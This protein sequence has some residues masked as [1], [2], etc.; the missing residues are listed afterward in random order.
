MVSS[1]GVFLVGMTVT[2]GEKT[3]ENCIHI[4]NT[5]DKRGFQEDFWEAPHIG[6]VKSDSTYAEGIKISL[7]L[8]EFKAAK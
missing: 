4:R 7:T 2:I 6:C 1:T 8:R 3:Y 5:T